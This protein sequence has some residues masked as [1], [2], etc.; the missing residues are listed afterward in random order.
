LIARYGP[1][2]T[3]AAG[4][5]GAAASRGAIWTPESAR[6]GAAIWTPGSETAPAPDAGRERS[7]LILPGQ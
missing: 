5:R 6:G 3:T 7:G 2:I 1:R 4:D